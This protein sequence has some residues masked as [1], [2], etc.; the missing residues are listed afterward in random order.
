MSYH[1][2]FLDINSLSSENYCHE[3]KKNNLLPNYMNQY[4]NSLSIDQDTGVFQMDE[5]KNIENMVNTSEEEINRS[6]ELEKYK[7]KRI[8]KYQDVTN[9]LK[10]VEKSRQDIEHIEDIIYEMCDHN[11]EYDYSGCGPHDG[12]DKVCKECNLYRR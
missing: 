3:N 4:I 10:M 9:Y 7:Q 2:L 11:W 1:S 12:P 8:Q 6:L 5:E